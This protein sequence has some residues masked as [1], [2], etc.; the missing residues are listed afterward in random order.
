M[1]RGFLHRS[2]WRDYPPDG[3][4]IAALSFLFLRFLFRIE[5]EEIIAQKTGEALTQL[6]VL[7]PY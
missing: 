3:Q 4:Q 1:Y 2:R 7:E 5:A 6:L